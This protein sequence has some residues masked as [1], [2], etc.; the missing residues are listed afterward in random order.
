MLPSAMG[1]P[2]ETDEFT[3]FGHNL[4]RVATLKGWTLSSVNTALSWPSGKVYRLC[5]ADSVKASDLFAVA[6]LLDME[7]EA[8]TKDMRWEL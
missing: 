5:R 7:P 4:L 2:I 1:R 8:L 3:A 6:R